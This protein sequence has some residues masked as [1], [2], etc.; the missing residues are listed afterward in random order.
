MYRKR[1]F[2]DRLLTLA[3]WRACPACYLIIA[4]VCF[5]PSDKHFALT[6]Y[7]HPYVPCASE[8]NLKLTRA[9]VWKK[10][11]SIS[12]TS[13]ML[14]KTEVNED[15]TYRRNTC[16]LC[17]YITISTRK[18]IAIVYEY[19]THVAQIPSPRWWYSG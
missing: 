1:H 6:E 10:T 11:R 3:Y 15:V 12:I 2:C 14:G 9:T 5:S 8:K 16:A 18:V 19:I 7:S 17:C 4:L 13:W